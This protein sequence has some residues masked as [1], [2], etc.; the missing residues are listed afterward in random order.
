MSVVIFTHF[1]W[2]WR[3]ILLSSS[4][5]S[6]SW[7][8]YVHHYHH[9]IL[10]SWFISYVSHQQSQSITH[11]HTTPPILYT[12][13]AYCSVGDAYIG[14]LW[15]AM[16][17]LGNRIVSHPL[18]Q[19][20]W[21]DSIITHILQVTWLELRMWVHQT[22]FGLGAMTLASTTHCSIR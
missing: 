19:F 3:Y 8:Y 2:H 16:W 7:I 4:I 21:K 1:L 17:M 12:I 20:V 9:S 13:D 10:Y 15:P 14:G 6:P 11:L 5:Q 22:T 18:A